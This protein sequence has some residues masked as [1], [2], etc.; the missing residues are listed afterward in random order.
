MMYDLT[1]PSIDKCALQ[2]RY[3][4]QCALIFHKHARING[5][6]PSLITYFFDFT[7]LTHII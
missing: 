4:W 6:R 1:V 7:L 5:S 2:V 3:E